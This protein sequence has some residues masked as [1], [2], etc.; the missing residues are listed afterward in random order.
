MEALASIAQMR[1]PQMLHTTV[2]RPPIE[3]SQSSQPLTAS[4]PTS[5]QPTITAPTSIASTQQFPSLQTPAHSVTQQ[6]G[7]LCFQQIAQAQFSHQQQDRPPTTSTLS[8]PTPLHSSVTLAT[9]PPKRARRRRSMPDPLK[10]LS[11]TTPTDVPLSALSLR[12]AQSHASHSALR[13]TITSHLA[14][15]CRRPSTGANSDAQA[16]LALMVLR[17]LERCPEIS[18]TRAMRSLSGQIKVSYKVLRK[19]WEAHGKSLNE[20]AQQT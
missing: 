18:P 13:K 9:H 1:L 16:L 2:A 7:F 19:A 8:Q 20:A 10:G 3:T 4:W 12:K 15:L 6:P 11:I 14:H 5:Q 17:M